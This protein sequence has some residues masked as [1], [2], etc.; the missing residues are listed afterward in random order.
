MARSDRPKN[1]GPR[2]RAA[3][4]AASAREQAEEAFDTAYEAAEDGFD[5]AHAFLKEQWE[6]RPLAVTATA[7]GVGVIIG[8]L[9]TSGRR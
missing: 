5:Q 4:I 3:A 2:A 1:G 9:L 6:E 7:L 8:M